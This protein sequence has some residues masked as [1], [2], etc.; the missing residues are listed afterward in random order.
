M[1]HLIHLAGVWLVVVIMSAQPTEA[2]II[3]WLEEL[4]G[5]G[6]FSNPFGFGP[7]ATIC[8]TRDSL[9]GR[10]YSPNNWFPC[11]YAEYHRFRTVED[12]NF[13]PRVSA[14][15][16]DFG[17]TIEVR[18]QIEIGAGLG[19]I[20]FDSGDQSTTR[21]SITLVRVA[22]QPLHFVNGLSGTDL[23]SRIAG[24]L[25]VYV[26]ETLIPGTLT[27]ADFGASSEFRARNDK[28]TSMGLLIDFGELLP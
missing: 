8:P 17:F 1:R 6:P 7:T 10:T 24:A 19:W 12:D 21:F 4:S 16:V 18:P 14:N 15:F 11:Y 20:D 22:V 5:P 2:G 23:R 28:I 3:D 25:K 27:G 13:F 26:R 9:N